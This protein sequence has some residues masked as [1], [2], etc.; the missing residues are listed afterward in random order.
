MT[1]VLLGMLLGAALVPGGASAQD[2]GAD[3]DG[4]AADGSA[5]AAGTA[6]PQLG[7]DVDGAPNLSDTEALAAR[8]SL[9]TEKSLATLTWAPFFRP[10]DYHPGYAETRIA[11]FADTSGSFGF[12]LGWSWNGA[13]AKLLA[14][15]A[16]PKAPAPVQADLDALLRSRLREFCELA[17]PGRD[18]AATTDDASSFCNPDVVV[19]TASD[20][21]IGFWQRTE[22]AKGP[23]ARPAPERAEPLPVP[24]LATRRAIDRLGEELRALKATLDAVRAGALGDAAGDLQ[25]LVDARAK[26]GTSALRSVREKEIRAAA[27]KRLDE[28]YDGALIPTVYGTATLFPIF[29]APAIGPKDAPGAVRNGAAEPLQRVDAGASLR[30]FLSRNLV[31]QWRAGWRRERPDPARGSAMFNTGLIGMD[32]GYFH[33]TGDP[34][35]DGFV[36]GWGTGVSATGFACG[37]ADGC[38]TAVT[39]PDPEYPEKLPL[40]G[41]VLAGAFI[42]ARRSSK[43]QIR[44]GLQLRADFV[45]GTIERTALEKNPTVFAILPT[46]AVGSSYWG[47]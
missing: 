22:A 19:A 32:L 30:Y 15:I 3:P 36:P 12:G 18:P 20:R 34:D 35:D 5:R 33:G 17:F 8:L 42:E 28:R 44:F 9:G 39:S 46:L 7:Q 2:T 47:L 1:R 16:F 31:L 43:L 45:H 27:Q 11:G 14:P 37:S 38:L 21:A 41:R 23:P 26:A 6:T 10:G 25:L 24:D 4:D 40:D 29:L 13:R